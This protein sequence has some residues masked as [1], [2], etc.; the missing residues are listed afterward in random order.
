[1]SAHWICFARRIRGSGKESKGSKGNEAIEKSR[2]KSKVPHRKSDEKFVKT[3]EKAVR[4]RKTAMR[5]IDKQAEETGRR[6]LYLSQLLIHR[7][8]FPS[9]VKY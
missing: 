8:N 6:K 3:R 2:S 5:P 9:S 7:G 4:D 1:M